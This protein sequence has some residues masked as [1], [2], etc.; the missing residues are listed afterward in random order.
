VDSGHRNK[1]KSAGSGDPG[2][3]VVEL[4]VSK[5][6]IGSRMIARDDEDERIYHLKK[7]VQ[8][9]IKKGNAQQRNGG[10]AACQKK[11]RKSNASFLNSPLCRN[12]ERREGREKTQ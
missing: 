5:R 12:A 9:Q 6:I 8:F 4:I 10:I 1:G 11:N 3:G 2:G 7:G